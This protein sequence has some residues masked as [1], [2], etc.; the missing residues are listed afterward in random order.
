MD[1]SWLRSRTALRER[2]A[3]PSLSRC[4]RCVFGSIRAGGIEIAVGGYI[5]DGGFLATHGH[6]SFRPPDPPNRVGEQFA[7]LPTYRRAASATYL[8]SR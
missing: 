1:G 8:A 5:D 4:G 3:R 2:R 6:R 7:E